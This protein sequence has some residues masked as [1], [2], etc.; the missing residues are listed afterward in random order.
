LSRVLSPREKPMP[1]LGNTSERPR[2][3][4]ERPVRPL[5]Y[6]GRQALRLRVFP[7]PFV[8]QGAELGASHL[9]TIGHTDDIASLWRRSLPYLIICCRSTRKGCRGHIHTLLPSSRPLRPLR[10]IMRPM[11][12]HEP[13]ATRHTGIHGPMAPVRPKSSEEV[14]STSRS[15]TYG[16]GGVTSRAQHGTSR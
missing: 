9:P 6:L 8:Q 16:K 15:T 12:P 14:A 2:Q 13:S 4:T 3:G 7:M 10:Y 1:H 11:R 5:R